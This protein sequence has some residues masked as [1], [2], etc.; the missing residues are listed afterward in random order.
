MKR[1]FKL[2]LTILLL[3]LTAYESSA[4]VIPTINPTAIFTNSNGETVVSGDETSAPIHGVFSAN[5]QDADGY[6]ASYEW[7]FYTD[8]IN[9]PFLVRF[10]QDTEFDFTNAGT[11]KIVCFATFTKGEQTINYTEEYWTSGE[12]T[13]IQLTISASKLE[14]PNAFSPNG[15]GINDIYKV[16]SNY[17]SIISFHGYIFSRWGQ[18]MYEWTDINGG[19]DGRFKGN[20]VKEGVYFALIKAKGADGKIYE[21]KRDVNL[22]REYTASS[23]ESSN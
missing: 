8:N 16:K 10:S 17:R 1:E 19:W 18:K 12:T 7:R 21:I 3:L 2:I 14:I 11:T 23:T 20:P 4:D 9:K 22:L 13:P 5:P 6:Q 15:D